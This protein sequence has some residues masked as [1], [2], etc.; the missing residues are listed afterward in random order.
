MEWKTHV[1]KMSI[2][3]KV[4]CGFNAA[5]SKIPASEGFCRHRHLILKFGKEKGKEWALGVLKQ[6]WQRTKWEK[7]L[8]SISR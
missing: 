8:Y 5:P 2:I 3:P 6:S 7:S 4:I 1:V